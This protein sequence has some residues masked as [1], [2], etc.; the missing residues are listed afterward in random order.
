[1]TR[2]K[3]SAAPFCL[4]A[5][6]LLGCGGQEGAGGP[7]PKPLTAEQQQAQKES[8]AEAQRTPTI[9]GALASPSDRLR[10][11][12]VSPPLRSWRDWGLGETAAD[13]LGRIGQPAVPALIEQ[14][15]N[16]D[17]R[18]RR[19]AAEIL[20]R[21]GPEAELAVPA[22]LQALNDPDPDLR[23]SA[24]RAIGQIGPAA[25]PAIPSL[26]HT[27]QQEASR[28]PAGDL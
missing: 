14:L 18:M 22:L 1:M 16:P 27:L 20:A 25:A 13:A 24:I 4:A 19:Q 7:P 26:I 28:P 6:S 8:L 10:T 12:P 21:I 17:L 2:F 23:K 11:Q 3:L 15:R 9:S 5:A